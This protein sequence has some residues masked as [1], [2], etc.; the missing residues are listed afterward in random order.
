MI[1]LK[2]IFDLFP[3]RFQ[4]FHVANLCDMKQLISNGFQ[5]VPD[6]PRDMDAT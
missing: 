5:K 4:A 6:S 2:R 3:N 1:V